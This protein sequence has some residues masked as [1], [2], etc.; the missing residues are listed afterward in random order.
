MRKVIQIS[1]S[2]APA[3]GYHQEYNQ[4]I[5]LCDDGTM[6]ELLSDNGKWMQ[7]PPIPQQEIT[8]SGNVSIDKNYP[9]R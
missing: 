4:V 9:C 6:W 5:A 3:C 2:V 7:L 1:N 8:D